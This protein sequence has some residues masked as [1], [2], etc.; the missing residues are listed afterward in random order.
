MK[1]TKFKKLKRSLR[2]AAG[3]TQTELADAVGASTV[4]VHNWE[5]GKRHP[6]PYFIEALCRVFECSEEELFE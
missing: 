6:H 5:R 4:T 2:A 1:R 3:M